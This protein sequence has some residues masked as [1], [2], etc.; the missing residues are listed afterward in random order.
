M[1]ALPPEPF[2]LADPALRRRAVAAA[3]GA[4]PFDRLVTGGTLVDMVTG[5]R[6]AAD[7]GL[8]G[9][10]IASVHAPG[11]RSDAT[12]FVDAAGGFVAPG[13]IDT[14][15][16]VESSMITPATYADAVVPRGVTTAVWDPHEFGNV[17]GVAGVD[18]AVEATRGLPLRFVVLAPSC[19]PSAPGLE[20]AGADFDAQAVSALLARPEIGGIAE[21]MAMRNVI[22]GEPRMS[23]IVDAGLAAGKPVCGHARS[24]S[25]ADLQAFMAAGISSDHELVSGDD[26]IAKLRAGLTI[27]LRGSHDHLL[28]DFV[29]ALNRLGHLPQ[30]VT[31]CTDD[32]FPDDLLNG[33][34]LDDVVRRLVRYGLRPEWALQAATLNAARRLGREDLGLIAA[35]RRADLVVFE[36]LADFRV[37]A[38]VANGVTVAEGGA[39][40]APSRRTATHAF[41]ASVKVAPLAP[42]A[43]RVPS[44]GRRVRVATIDRPRFTQWGSAETEVAD[45]FV[46]PPPGATLIAVVHR[47]GRA[48]AVP[49][50]GFL[51]EWGAWKGAF[52]TTV[53]HD[54]HNLTVFGG[55]EIDMAIAAN[56]VIAAGGGMAVA[57]G[58]QVRALLPLPVSGLVSE[59]PLA[60]VAEGFAALRAAMDDVV[61]WQPPYLVFKACFGATL[62]CNAGPHQTDRG[63]ADVATG[64]V[65]AS[66]V[67]DILE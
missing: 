2:D 64:R 7:I 3:R 10:L 24:L 5:E 57:A 15:M 48:E 6:R 45:G 23:A 38:V 37:R 22:D 44:R 43:F 61:E 4:A 46:V 65:L 12:S 33:G 49:R 41:A 21:V 60:D 14:H 19:V 52:A 26:L 17:H 47:H 30:T 29:A 1:S 50:V 51:R 42:E 63:I 32:V 67:L 62:A 56:A 53:A 40:S 11:S 9:P 31:L 25:G 55:N 35:G 34:G 54:S 36:D 28:P 66:P 13:L 16:H 39:T 58:G 59:A 18:W 20:L 27:E 8:V